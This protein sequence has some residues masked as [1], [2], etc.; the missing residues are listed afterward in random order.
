METDICKSKSIFAS[1]LNTGLLATLLAPVVLIILLLSSASATPKFKSIPTQFIAALGDPSANSGTGAQKW[2]IW[3]TDP[4]INGLSFVLY[5]ILKNAGGYAPGNWKFDVR[6][7]WLDENGLIMEK[8][9]FPVPAGKY[10]VT[11]EREVTAMLTIFP[12]DENGEQRWELAKGAKLFDVT[13]MPCRSAR[14]TPANGEN[15]CIP[16]NAVKASFPV[17]PGAI[18]PP[19]S[20]CKKLDYSVLIVIGLP[21]N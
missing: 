7:W 9:Q 6:D 19:V 2:G 5:D 15:S 14:Y 17:D 18:M 13:H 21:I 3:R 8:P 10:M 4:G 20:G 1:F 12:A 16:A 11:G